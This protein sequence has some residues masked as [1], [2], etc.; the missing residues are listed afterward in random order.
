[1]ATDNGGPAETLATLKEM[2]AELKR[3]TAQALEENAKYGARAEERHEE[4]LALA[5]Q[6]ER[7][8]ARDFF[9]AHALAGLLANE[10]HEGTISEYAHDAY[11]HADAML[12]A[13]EGK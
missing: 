13:R 2:L 4:V 10:N 7:E 6:R 9:A 8:S 5:A 12:K 1:M 11:Q 3:Q